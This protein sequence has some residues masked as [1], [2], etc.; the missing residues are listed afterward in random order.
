MSK[1]FIAV[2]LSVILLSACSFQSVTITP[3]AP[4]VQN[5]QPTPLN[6]QESIPTATA[7][8][9]TVA[10]TQ[11]PLPTL[12][13]TCPGVPAPLV[14]IGQQVTVL[15]DNSDKLK[16][17]SE[18]RISADTVIRELD[19]STQL[20]IT[21][22]PV[23]VHSDESGTSYW[24]WQVNVLSSGE[25]GWVA[26]GDSL[27]YFME[28]STAVAAVD[29]PTALVCTNMDAPRVVIGQQVT[30][31]TENTDKLKLRENPV[32]SPNTVLMELDQ[33]TKLN[34]L[35]GPVC[36]YSNETKIYYWLW[37]VQVIPG[38]ETGWVAEGDF[39]RTFIE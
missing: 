27:H 19:Q 12:A 16:L 5:I 31:V 29:T 1:R 36:A 33:F 17:R 18:P 3:P 38:G 26:E 14:K 39:F 13:L 15:V 30:V 10:A 32:F 11:Q 22:G 6:L 28:D 34:I 35:E 8:P 25:T 2:L 21:Q 9:L 7:T 20:S 24:F 23:C 37:K 4:E